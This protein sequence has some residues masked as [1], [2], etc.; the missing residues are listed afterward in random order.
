MF[1]KWYKITG[2]T[3]ELTTAWSN[4]LRK[5]IVIWEENGNVEARISLNPVEAIRMQ[6]LM[7]RNNEEQP[8]YKLQLV[9]A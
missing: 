8:F 7:K 5:D 3:Q 2:L 9:P 1:E 6:H 4:D